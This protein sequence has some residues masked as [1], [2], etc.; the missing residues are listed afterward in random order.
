MV[1][2]SLSEYCSPDDSARGVVAKI[3][4]KIT[5]DLPRAIQESVAS[6]SVLGSHCKA[7]LQGTIDVKG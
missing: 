3:H 5:S 1:A 4:R 2:C 7:H 6:D